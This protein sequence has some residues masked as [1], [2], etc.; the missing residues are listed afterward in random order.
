MT[1]WT[2]AEIG[3]AIHESLKTWNSAAQ[4]WR[5]RGTFNTTNNVGIVDL[6]PVLDNAGFKLLERNATDG[7][8]IETICDALMEPAP[9]A[10][11]WQGTD[12][13]TFNDVK[14]ALEWAVN[15]FLVRTSCVV[16][17]YTQAV[18]VIPPAGRLVL[19]EENISDIRRAD[20]L[21]LTDSRRHHLWRVDEWG[22]NA[23]QRLWSTNAAEPE[24]YSITSVDPLIVQ[25]APVP[26]N[27]GTF[28][29]QI[30]RSNANLDGINTLLSIPKDFTWVVKW[31]ALAILLTNDGQV[32]DPERGAYATQRYEE[33][34]AIATGSAASVLQAE[35]NGIP[36]QVESVVELDTTRPN[37]RSE[38]ATQPQQLAMNG[39]NLLSMAPTPNAG[40]YSIT[41]DVV[42]N[43]PLPVNPADFIQVGKEYIDY[44]LNYA[45][46]LLSFKM[47]GAE[48][49]YTQP[50]L[51]E[52]YTAALQYNAKLRA[53]GQFY[54]IT[55]DRAKLEKAERP[56]RRE[57]ANGSSSA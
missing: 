26:V 13:F 4:Y 12:K 40:P 17:S 9:I 1:F 7:S 55:Q 37:W 14:L 38:T 22:L 34:V 6:G 46:H 31:G 43:A 27:G 52:M 28:E 21:S 29:A 53:N 41:M 50:Y 11:V 5:G 44:V 39:L 47:G 24:N 3:R 49:A 19:T 36:V 54:D 35:I 16:L 8:V 15:D 57:L 10:G 42:R 23:Q 32:R 51:Q 20:W 30:V 2:D 33:G 56:S 45:Q 18:G 48:F 25:L